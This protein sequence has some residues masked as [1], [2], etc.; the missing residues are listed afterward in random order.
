MDTQY[1]SDRLDYKRLG[2]RRL[3][4]HFD[5]GDITSDGTRVRL[6]SGLLKKQ[7]SV[8]VSERQSVEYV[9]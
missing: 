5:G 6:S 1:S 2:R 3:T 7:C 8:L 4:A 9:V